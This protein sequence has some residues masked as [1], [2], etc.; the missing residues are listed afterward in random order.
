MIKTN[1]P[2]TSILFLDIETA[3]GS[4][5]LFEAGASLATAWA[6]VAESKYKDE[7]DD[8][9]ILY[10]RYAALYPEFGRIVCVSMGYFKNETDF[11]VRAYQNTDEKQLIT[12]VGNEI[13]KLSAS[14]KVLGGHNL[15]QFDV[16]FLIRRALVHNLHLP[17]MFDLYAAKPWEM[18][19]FIDTMEMWKSTA[20]SL[21]SATLESIA[22]A[23]GFK[24]PK[25]D[26]NGSMVSTYYYLPEG[27]DFAKIGKY[28]SGDVI[29]TACLYVR[30]TKG[31]S[32][33][34]AIKVVENVV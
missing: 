7:G 3:H 10:K 14:Y 23:F 21:G 29:V 5:A 26:M 31:D 24:S 6:H 17:V 19:Q 22:A 33:L 11:C 34:K 2:H 25:E 16:P 27:P 9:G 18:T 30:M 4:K 32:A 8:Y 13:T 15:K 20:M 28:C 1:I 12:D